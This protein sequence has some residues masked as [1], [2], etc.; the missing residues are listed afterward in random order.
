MD[1]TRAWTALE[2]LSIFDELYGYPLFVPLMNRYVNANEFP[3]MADTFQ[4]LGLVVNEGDVML[5]DDA[6]HRS[7]RDTI[8]FIP[9]Q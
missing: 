2:V 4:S 1:R 8:M 9:N 7:L 6:D 3:D 5:T